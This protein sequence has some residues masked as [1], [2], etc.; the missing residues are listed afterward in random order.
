MRCCVLLLLLLTPP[1]PRFPPQMNNFIAAKKE[2]RCSD[3]VINKG[4]WAYSRHPNYLGEILFWWGLYLL[5]AGGSDGWVV[6]GPLTI[7]ALFVFVS[8]KLMEDRQLKNKGEAFR[9][10]Q[11]K[12][13]SG[14]LLLPSFAN[15]W[16]GQKL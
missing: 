16:I 10:Y 5:G 11:R 8:V 13:G 9:A 7:T 15:E 14:L 2:G 6:A 4:L 3:A 12:V 1:S